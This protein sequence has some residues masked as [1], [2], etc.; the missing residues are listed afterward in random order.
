MFGVARIALICEVKAHKRCLEAAHER[1]MLSYTQMLPTAVGGAVHTQD[2]RKY[3]YRSFAKPRYIQ[4]GLYLPSCSL[5][6]PAPPHWGRAIGA[7]NK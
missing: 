7:L 4:R 6:V 3:L 2:I 5:K 1:S